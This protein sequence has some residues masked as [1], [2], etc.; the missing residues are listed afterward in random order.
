MLSWRFLKLLNQDEKA[1][2]PGGRLGR[3]QDT[4][5]IGHSDYLSQVPPVSDPPAHCRSLCHSITPIPLQQRW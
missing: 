3:G 4:K 2:N 1:T 5:D